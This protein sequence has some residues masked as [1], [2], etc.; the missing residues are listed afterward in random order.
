MED[1][2]DIKLEK[3]L[4]KRQTISLVVIWAI[5]III[6]TLWILDPWGPEVSRME[7]PQKKTKVEKT[8]RFLQKNNSGI[9][10]PKD[11]EEKYITV[12][13]PV[14]DEDGN[15][16]IVERKLPKKQVLNGPEELRLSKYSEKD[17]QIIIKLAAKFYSLCGSTEPMNFIFDEDGNLTS[18]ESYSE[19]DLSVSEEEVN[20][21]KHL[22]K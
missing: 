20:K 19:E 14:Y 18:C 11:K 17:I 7:F 12:S 21:Y 3:K 1:Q 13:Q 4:K 2:E 15:E 8:N 10:K 5:V 22:F 9:T 16:I 6:P